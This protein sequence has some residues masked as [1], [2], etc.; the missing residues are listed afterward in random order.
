MKIG[1]VYKKVWVIQIIGNLIM[2]IGFQMC[3][4]NKIS[5]DN[6]N[7]PNS[8]KFSKFAKHHEKYFGKCEFGNS[9]S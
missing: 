4:V 2:K 1:K 8:P 5:V 7:L 9:Y 3:N 6:S